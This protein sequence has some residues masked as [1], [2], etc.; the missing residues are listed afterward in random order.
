[1]TLDIIYVCAGVKCAVLG[2]L[3]V[4][5]TQINNNNNNNNN[6]MEVLYWDLA[7]LCSPFR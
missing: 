7:L 5:C 2:R 1:M 6:N 3:T 4:Y